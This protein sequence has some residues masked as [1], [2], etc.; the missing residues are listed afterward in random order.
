MKDALDF[1]KNTWRL[2]F[3]MFMSGQ[4]VTKITSEVVSFALVWQVIK[5]TNSATMLA[6]TTLVYVVP[7]IALLPFVGPLAD[8]MNKKFLIIAPDLVLAAL[9]LVLAV[10]GY[11]FAHIPLA[12]IFVILFLRGVAAS[13]QSPAV[14][15]INPT[16]VPSDF[17]TKAAGQSSMIN[18]MSYLIAPAIAAAVFDAI[19]LYVIILFDVIGAV[20][21][22]IFTLLATIPSFKKDTKLQFVG[23]MKEGWETLRSNKGVFQFV[24]VIGIYQIFNSPI[25]TMLPLLV[26]GY[27]H[28]SFAQAGIVELCW[29]AG[30]MLGAFVIGAFGAGKNRMYLV[31]FAT[32]IMGVMFMSIMFFPPNFNGYIAFAILIT[33]TAIIAS[34]INVPLNAIPQSKYPP[35][36]LGSVMGIIM[37]IFMIPQPIGLL[38]AGPVV[39]I[40]GVEVMFSFVGVTAIIL[41]IV[42]RVLPKV[43]ALDK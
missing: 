8:R 13:F 7:T 37:T 32:L 25:G 39:D 4:F 20:L 34:G 3:Y 29:S 38:L 24:L 27:F 15:S 19:P 22:T 26:T 2:N 40:I 16:I 17:I 21:G 6:L 41:A 30:A 31:V 43:W 14:S 35:E 9:A 10:V 5:E 1:T 33:I 42:M 23:D 28:A 11:F 18:Q 36:K 12:L